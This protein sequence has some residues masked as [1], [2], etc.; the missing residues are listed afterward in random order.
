MIREEINVLDGYELVKREKK[1]RQIR[2]KST[3]FS[4]IK[5]HFTDFRIRLLN[6]K[7]EREKDKAVTEGYKNP[8][9]ERDSE[10]MMKRASNIARLEEKIKILDGEEVPVDY[11]SKRA[12]KIKKA[13]MRNISYT[14]DNIYAVGL[15]NK[16]EVF[17]NIETPEVVPMDPEVQE[18]IAAKVRKI[19]EE[20]AKEAAKEVAAAEPVETPVQE[21]VA[22]YEPDA[23]TKAE[24]KAEIDSELDK[25]KHD[26]AQAVEET[27]LPHIDLDE[28]QAVVNDAFKE[29]QDTPEASATIG[30]EE[31]KD[32]V[33]E[34]FDNVDVDSKISL[35]DIK[36]EVDEAMDRIVSK[37]ANTD[38]KIDR[39]NEDG[40]VTVYIP[41]GSDNFLLITTFTDKAPDWSNVKSQTNDV[42]VTE[43]MTTTTITWKTKENVSGGSSTPTTPVTGGVYGLRG[44]FEGG[45]DWGTTVLLSEVSNGIYEGTITTTGAAAFKVVR[46]QENNIDYV[47]EWIGKNGGDVAISAAGT[48]KITFNA[49]T[50]AITFTAA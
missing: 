23:I 3:S 36:S 40:S 29:M 14:S 9:S 45:N 10:K 30:S 24:I 13:M 21:E 8:A 31:I 41:E 1:P 19:M 26:K 47:E 11:V 17:N 49:S 18:E 15:E 43:T 16:E 2:T 46:V 20:D 44:N 42:K 12:I 50:K 32:V 27:K 7:L 37:N 33:E 35:E 6:K 34:S 38:A 25:I 39:F 22:G 48:Y 28:I 5:K 4:Q